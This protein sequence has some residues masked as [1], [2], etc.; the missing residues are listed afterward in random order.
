MAREAMRLGALARQCRKRADARQR[1]HLPPAAARASAA[2]LGGGRL[3]SCTAL[4]QR[5]QLPR[6]EGQRR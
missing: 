5:R 3:H 1:G 6:G 4:D 2:G